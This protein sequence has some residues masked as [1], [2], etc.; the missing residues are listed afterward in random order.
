MTSAKPGKSMDAAKL[1]TARKQIEAFLK[2]LA[3]RAGARGVDPWDLRQAG[4]LAAV[5]AHQNYD[6]EKAAWITHL[7]RP[8]RFAMLR[9]LLS[10]GSPVTLPRDAY[11]LG[12]SIASLELSE[13][14]AERAASTPQTVRQVEAHELMAEL[15]TRYGGE[16]ARLLVSLIL[17][18]LTVEE[19]ADMA[20]LSPDDVR[21][22]RNFALSELRE[23]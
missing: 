18:L 13:V 2:L 10:L 3:H 1:L 4:L 9:E 8:V 7:Y 16:G 5:R 11:E 21:E 14:T 20:E 17:G 15:E 23:P 12:A 22:F 6:P 19:A